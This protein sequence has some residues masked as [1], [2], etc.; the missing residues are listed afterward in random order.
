[1]ASEFELET[2]HPPLPLHE[3]AVLPVHAGKRYFLTGGARGLGAAV[4]RLLT[5]QG[6]RVFVTDILEEEAAATAA[7]LGAS[8]LHARI[9]VGD[10]ASI[11]AA[12]STARERLG[13]FDGA[14]NIA[15]IVIHPDPLDIPWETWERQFEV[16]VFGTY[17][18]VREV[19]AVMIA[20][21]SRGA[22]VNTASEAGKQGHVDSLA[23]SGSKAAVISMTRLLAEALAPHDIN[24]NCVC[25]GGM[26][27]EMLREVAVNYARIRHEDDP[28]SI[29]DR[30]TN[31][32]LKRHTEVSE[33]A[34]VF[35]FLLSDAAMVV[36]GQAINA[37][38]G[39]TPY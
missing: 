29:F 27:T 4:A 31:K 33:V 5:A 32:Q 23:Y 11:R 3:P 18:V 1:M 12:V 7:S 22:I 9:D 24:V 10:P 6:A 15:G 13:G 25:P 30:M 2:S 17:Q 8:E 36:R 39:G 26:P 38:A 28:G 14:V 35:S 20:E 37:D 34:Q 19:T 16:N 21:G